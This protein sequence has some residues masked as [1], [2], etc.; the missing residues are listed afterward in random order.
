MVAPQ[1]S[2]SHHPTRAMHLPLHPAPVGLGS[3]CRV[4]PSGDPPFPLASHSPRGG[5]S[6]SPHL[7]TLSPHPIGGG[8]LLPLEGWGWPSRDHA[9]SGNRFSWLPRSSGF[10]PFDRCHLPFLSCASCE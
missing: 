5:L 6:P 7:P 4:G 9:S 3:L 1:R 8:S 10:P 2:R